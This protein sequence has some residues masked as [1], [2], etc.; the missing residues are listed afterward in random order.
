MEVS[1][2]EYNWAMLFQ[3][4]INA[5]TWPYRLREWDSDPRMIALARSSS[6]CKRHTHPL[7][8]EDVP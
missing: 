2:R 6:N 7:V 4:H 5:W 3:G 8:R 1:A